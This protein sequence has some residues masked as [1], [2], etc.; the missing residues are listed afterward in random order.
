MERLWEYKKGLPYFKNSPNSYPTLFHFVPWHFGQG[1]SVSV[2][3]SNLIASPHFVHLYKPFPGFSPV[4][5]IKFEFK[6]LITYKKLLA[7]FLDRTN[8]NLFS[9]SG[10]GSFRS[11]LSRNKFSCSCISNTCRCF[12]HKN[13]LFKIKTRFHH[14]GLKTYPIIYYSLFVYL[15]LYL[16]VANYLSGMFHLLT[17]A[18]C[19]QSPVPLDYSCHKMFYTFDSPVYLFCKGRDLCHAFFVLCPRHHLTFVNTTYYKNCN[20]PIGMGNRDNPSKKT[21]T[22]NHT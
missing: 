19:G 14:E 4:E 15:Q 10:L 9:Y 12:T 8:F 18:Y 13:E 16:K 5:Y 2:S 17:E 7:T 6:R 21:V 3:S 22:N 11:L 1:G 20:S